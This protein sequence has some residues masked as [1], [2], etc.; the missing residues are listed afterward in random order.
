MTKIYTRTGDKGNTSLF[1][2]QRVLKNDPYIEALG[3]VDECNSSIG[4]ALSFME[5]GTMDPL[6]KELEIIQHA[7]FDLGAALATP[8]TRATNQKIEK[9]RFD[10]EATI[11]LEKWID[12]MNSHLTPLKE[13]IL[14]GGHPTAAML[15]LARSLC[16][17]AER[18]IIP[19]HQHADVS[20]P[21]LIY[22]NRLSDYLFM[23]ARYANH[24]THTPETHWQHHKPSVG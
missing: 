15:H 20:N 1:T 5:P 24:L 14:P 6:K 23:A 3:S 19:L 17:R 21:V 11:V 7:L 4:A 10:E 18:S 8:R 2:G 9:T 13:F 16:R 22:I 12:Q